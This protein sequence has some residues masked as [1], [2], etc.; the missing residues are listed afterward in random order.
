MEIF[1]PVRMLF[2][3]QL[4]DDLTLL[5]DFEVIK[6]FREINSINFWHLVAT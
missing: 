6:F 5:I 2:S 4:T 1:V 3:R